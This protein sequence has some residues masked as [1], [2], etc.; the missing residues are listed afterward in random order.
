MKKFRDRIWIS[1]EDYDIIENIPAG[2][3][4]TE[5]ESEVLRRVINQYYFSYQDDYIGL[6]FTAGFLI[7]TFLLMFLGV[8]IGHWIFG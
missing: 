7:Y 8:L 4:M 2:R 1:D 5:K 3:K 6:K